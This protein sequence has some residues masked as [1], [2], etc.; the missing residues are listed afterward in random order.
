[1]Q[2]VELI[3]FPMDQYRG[4]CTLTS[5]SPD[6]LKSAAAQNFVLQKAQALGLS[7]AGMSGAPE[8]YPVSLDGTPL[9]PLVPT[10]GP[11]KYSGVYKVAGGI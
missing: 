3:E 5:D 11:L 2:G 9:N 10:P 8:V 7:R 1:M 6:L 4:T